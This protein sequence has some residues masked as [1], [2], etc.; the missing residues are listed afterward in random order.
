MENGNF[1]NNYLFYFMLSVLANICQ[2]ADFDMNVKQV[3]NDEIMK[4]LEKQNNVLNEQTEIYLKEI[5]EQNK[6]II[7]LLQKKM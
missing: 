2:L 1:N 6:L 5:V 4:V 7:E 3:S